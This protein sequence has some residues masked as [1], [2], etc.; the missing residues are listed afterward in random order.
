MLHLSEW[1]SNWMLSQHFATFGLLLN[2]C[3]WFGLRHD[4]GDFIFQGDVEL[5][6]SV[7]IPVPGICRA[8]EG[9]VLQT[10]VTTLSQLH[11]SYLPAQF[12]DLGWIFHK[13][14]NPAQQIT[15][16]L[17]D[18]NW[19]KTP[20]LCGRAAGILR[21]HAYG[22]V[23]Q[24]TFSL[25]ISDIGDRPYEQDVWQDVSMQCGWSANYAVHCCVSSWIG[26]GCFGAYDIRSAK[27]NVLPI[28]IAEFFQKAEAAVDVYDAAPDPTTITK[29]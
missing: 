10:W 12:P 14:C 6:E 15:T 29:K 11:T 23:L 27:E 19:F 28:S 18:C 5:F 1:Q 26:A 24:S 9:S 4:K 21:F 22:A 2:Q 13:T 16:L 20:T 17:S 8:S 7:G 3:S 25:R